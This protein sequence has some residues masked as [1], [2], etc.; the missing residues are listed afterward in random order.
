MNYHGNE[1]HR[2]GL[3]RFAHPGGL[4]Q[5]ASRCPARRHPPDLSRRA[6]ALSPTT[7]TLQS[8]LYRDRTFRINL[9]NGTQTKRLTGGRALT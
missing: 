4:L 3:W 6:R 9:D 1:L 2:A 5:E 7:V 8:A